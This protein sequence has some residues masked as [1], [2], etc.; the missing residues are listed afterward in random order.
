[1]SISSGATSASLAVSV[2]W[3]VAVSELDPLHAGTIGF[4][5]IMEKKM[6]A[7]IF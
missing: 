7:T 5:G 3:R 1:M 4:V 6:E 2:S